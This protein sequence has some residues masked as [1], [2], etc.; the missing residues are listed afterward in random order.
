MWAFAYAKAKN[1][2]QARKAPA[3]SG[4]VWTWTALD[5]DSKLVVTW[6]V[7]T[8]GLETAQPFIEDLASRLRDRIQLT[9]DGHGPYVAAV[10]D[11]FGADVDFAQLIKIYG[12]SRSSSA[13]AR[14]SASG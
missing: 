10:E 1:V 9:S 2:D 4:D 6:A 11:A 3:G 13:T 14:R 12:P 8:R 5:A 7:G